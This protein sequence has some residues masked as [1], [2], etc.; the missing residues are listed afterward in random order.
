MLIP[1]KIEKWN[2][3]VDVRAFDESKLKSNYSIFLANAVKICN[4]YPCRIKRLFLVLPG[5]SAS[6]WSKVVPFKH[7]F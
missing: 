5:S 4:A 2:I 3:I 6:L 7:T 1:G